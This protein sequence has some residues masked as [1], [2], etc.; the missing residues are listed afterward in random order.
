MFSL[1]LLQTFFLKRVT[2]VF[3][4]VF[5]EGGKALLVIAMSYRLLIR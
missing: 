3:L 1:N 5:N 4:F 2:G